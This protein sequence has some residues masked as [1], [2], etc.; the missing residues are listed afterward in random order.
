[1]I[2]IEKY[3][4][5]KILKGLNVLGGHLGLEIAQG[6]FRELV[7]LKLLDSTID[8]DSY[9][10]Q[11]IDGRIQFNNTEEL[12]AQLNEFI[13]KNT[14][15]QGLFEEIYS[16][17][18]NNDHRFLDNVISLLN[19]ID[20]DNKD[21]Q[22]DI[23]FRNFL[24][25]S[26]KLKSSINTTSPSIRE[27]ISE[28]LSDREI[29]NL[30]NPSIGYGSLSL[31]V[32]SNHKGINIYGQ[33]INNE[34]IR[35]CKMQLILDKRIEELDN[36][37]QGNTIVSPGNIDENGLRK[38][39]CIVCDPPYGLRDWGYEEILN[40][41]PYNRFHRGMPSKSLGDYAFITHVIE[42][43]N[44][45]GIAIMIE[46]AG[47]LFREGAEGILRQKLVEE[48]LI[49]TVIALPNN[50][51]F[52]TAIPVNLIIFNKAKKEKDILFI[53][54]AKEVMVNK[55]LTTLSEDMVKKVVRVYEERL[56]IEGFSRRV[57]I[58][59]IQFNNFNLNIQRYIEEISEKE[60]LDI[61]EIGKEI[62]YLTVKL[63]QIQAEINQFFNK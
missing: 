54:V 33:D 49:D 44:S 55:V 3:I 56:D 50:M 42:S 32:A 59:E 30:Y 37:N 5:E 34:M 48:N 38:F 60:T 63:Q 61:K 2:N 12:F 40:Y 26:P 47:V 31:Q 4:A 9:F 43:L 52:G 57:D 11:R 46:P 25:I 24:D 23:L 62:E 7:F 15:L 35:I 16:I 19:D 18:N 20:F 17:R 14:I 1:M 27:L 36:I 45:E 28:L 8:R 13:K 58:D 41:D 39:D 21:I 10:E 51:M 6:I 29:R 22:L 53:D